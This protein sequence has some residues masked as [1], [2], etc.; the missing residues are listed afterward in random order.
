MSGRWAVALALLGVVSAASVAHAQVTAVVEAGGGTAAIDQGDPSSVLTLAPRAVWAMPRFRLEAAGAYS[1]YGAFGWGAQGRVSGSYTL[2]L[3]PWLRAEAAAGLGGSTRSGDRQS[4]TWDLT[5]RLHALGR[6]HGAWLGLGPARALERGTALS[7]FRLEGGAWTRR[8]PF[9]LDLLIR[10]AEFSDTIPRGG[11]FD[12][13]HSMPDTLER[14]RVLQYTDVG[15]AAS[16]SAGRLEL[17]AGA[18]RRLGPEPFRRSWWNVDATFWITPQLGVV[19]ATGR[20]PADLALVLPGGKYTT[21]SLRIP[22]GIRTAPAAIEPA[23]MAVPRG[24]VVERLSPRLVRLALAAP[25][26]RTV[27]LMGDFTDWSPV[28]LRRGEDGRWELVRPIPSGLRR[29]NVRYDGGEW[30]VPPGATAAA[31]EFGGVAGVF[32]VE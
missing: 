3:A 24:L 14:R 2:P 20:Y 17:G 21:L 6:G 18:G 11:T 4:G 16:W 29:A 19:A 25:G 28:P 8:G 31:D 23:A 5:A 15:A 27:E 10:R 12:S 26:A 13:L 1:E 30:Q 9:A 22:L 32:V 7:M